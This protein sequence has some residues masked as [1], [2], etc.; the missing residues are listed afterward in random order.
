[1]GA[2]DMKLPPAQRKKRVAIVFPYPNI[3]YSPSVVNLYDALCDDFEVHILTF[4]PSDFS[5]QRLEG[6][7]VRYVGIPLWMRRIVGKIGEILNFN[8][9][10]RLLLCLLARAGRGQSFDEAIGVDFSG[11]WVAARLSR[12]IHLLSL[13]LLDRDPFRN[14]TP[15]RRIHSVII[16]SEERYR[17]LFPKTDLKRF[18]IQN[19]PVYRP[20]P[21]QV[22]RRNSLVFCGT[23][24]VQFGIFRCLDFI[25]AEPQLMLT[26]QGAVPAPVRTAI[27]ERYPK[28]LRDERLK[29]NDLY[30]EREQLSEYL[31]QFYIGFCCYD[32][33]VP[34]M[35][36]FNYLS[37]PSGK[38][39]AYYAAGV[40]VIASNISGLRSV[41]EFE[42][43][44]LID[45][46]TPTALRGAVARIERDHARMRE[47]CF[48]AAA[49]FSFDKACQPFRDFLQAGS[50]Q[51]DS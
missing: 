30:I 39:F 9:Y 45:E 32:L 19:A 16:Q 13:E 8:L 51:P 44:V 28:L 5:S 1:M 31:S 34:G 48:K 46:F 7:Q 42:A 24:I 26:I 3:A 6:R 20:L 49:H 43:G 38:L 36:T 11:L 21:P 4:T 27:Q 12:N 41:E 2:R 25:A 10:H 33:T 17:Y 37:A 35:N 23:A 18:L 50:S 47:N 40:P 15:L 29:I 22:P 14:A